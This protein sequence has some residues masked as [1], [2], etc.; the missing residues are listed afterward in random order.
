M[1][2]DAYDDVSLLDQRDGISWVP[3]LGVRTDLLR[4]VGQTELVLLAAHRVPELRLL[5]TKTG[6]VTPL[7]LTGLGQRHPNRA[8]PPAEPKGWT[9]VQIRDGGASGDPVCAIDPGTTWIRDVRVERKSPASGLWERVDPLMGSGQTPLCGQ[10][11]TKKAGNVFAKKAASGARAPAGKADDI[12]QLLVRGLA[13]MVEK[14]SKRTM[15]DGLIA[16]GDRIVIERAADAAGTACKDG[17]ACSLRKIGV[18]LLPP[19]HAQPKPTKPAVL[20]DFVGK[21]TVVV[22]VLVP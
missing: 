17:A 9:V 21:G 15:F 4:R 5:N 19:T 16:P 1:G 8:L 6:K 3:T 2:E 7:P 18:T 12:A 11:T 13:T 14:D 22:G 20:G 10:L